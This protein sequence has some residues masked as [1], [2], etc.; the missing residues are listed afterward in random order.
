MAVTSAGVDRELTLTVSGEVDHHAAAKIMAE[1]ERQVEERLPRAL[2]LDLGG[3]TFMDSSGIAVVLRCYK[4]VGELGG[5]LTVRNTPTQ[6]RKVLSA[7]GLERMIRFE[8]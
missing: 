2:I 8:E 4:R 3:V 6:A 5:S 7:A 1:V